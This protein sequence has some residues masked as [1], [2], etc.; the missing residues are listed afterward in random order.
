MKKQANK[1]NT[2]IKNNKFQILENIGF[3][4]LKTD[5]GLIMFELTPSKLSK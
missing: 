1:K 5:S 3:K 4:K 2:V